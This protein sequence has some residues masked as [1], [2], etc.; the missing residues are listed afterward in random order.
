MFRTLKLLSKE[1][2]TRQFANNLP[3]NLQ[4]SK[5]KPKKNKCMHEQE[6]ASP[7]EQKPNAVQYPKGKDNLLYYLMK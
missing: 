6:T 5:Y 7:Q 1:R 4:Q 2:G 3:K